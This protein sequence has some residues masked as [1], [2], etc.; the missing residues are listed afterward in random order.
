M[1]VTLETNFVT[2]HSRHYWKGWVER[3]QIKISFILGCSLVIISLKHFKDFDV[4]IL[5]NIIALVSCEAYL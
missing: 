5:F 1:L 4:Y 2:V 3:K